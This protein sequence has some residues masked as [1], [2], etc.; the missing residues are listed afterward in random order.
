MAQRAVDFAIRSLKIRKIKSKT[1][2]INLFTYD[3]DFCRKKFNDN[4]ISDKKFK[5][6]YNIYGDGCLKILE[7][8]KQEKISDN[9]I[10]AEYLY[11]RRNEMCHTLL[12]F[13]SQRNSG[14]YFEID[15]IKR[16]VKILENYIRKNNSVSKDKW[17]KEKLSLQQYIS[18][19]TTFI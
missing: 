9:F 8:S 7:I 19:L 12:D 11:V 4:G 2:S 1:K 13:F 3:E 14:V 6:L 18:K 5:R 15:Q 16:Y 17:E 10:I